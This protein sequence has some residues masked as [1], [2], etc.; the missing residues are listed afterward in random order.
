M[1]TPETRPVV[2][3]VERIALIGT[4]S[5]DSDEVLVQKAT[6][7]LAVV[8]SAALAVAWVGTYLALGL[9]LSAAIPFGSRGR[10]TRRA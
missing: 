3:L 9:P 5:S 2:R 10:R 4:T 8:V 7:T 1:T 6:L